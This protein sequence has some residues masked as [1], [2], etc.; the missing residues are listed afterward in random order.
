M[1]MPLI[2]IAI[3]TYERPALLERALRSVLAQ[4]GLDTGDVEIVVVDNSDTGSARA[5]ID[6]LN[7]TARPQIRYSQA[8]PA[9]ISVAR[10]TAIAARNGGAWIAFLDDDLAV[11]A[12]LAGGDSGC[13]RAL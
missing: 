3:C 12:G 11:E 1:S 2:S 9:N 7:A 5:V 13:H 4:G 8:H 6:A 10:N